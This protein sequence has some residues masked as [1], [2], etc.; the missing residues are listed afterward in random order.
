MQEPAKWKCNIRAAVLAAL[1]LIPFALLAASPAKSPQTRADLDRAISLLRQ[2]AGMF[3]ADAGRRVQLAGLLMRGGYLA[4]ARQELESLLAKQPDHVAGILLLS[5]LFRL[6]FQ[7]EEGRQWMEKARSLAP[8]D[9]SVRLLEADYAKDRHDFAA[10]ADILQRMRR[11]SQVPPEALCALG[12]VHY[13]ENRF[14]QAVEILKECVALDPAN[15]RA[16][17]FLSLIHRVRQENEEWKTKGR[18]SV[19]CDPFDAEALANL[20]NI[21]MRGEKKLK[22]GYREAQQSLRFN[23]YCLTAHIYLG[24]GWTSRHYREDHPPSGAEK[25]RRWRELMQKAEKALTGQDWNEAR[26]AL[27]EAL[28]LHPRSLPA[29]IRRGSVD[30]LQGNCRQALDWFFR[31]LRI[32]PGYGLAHYGI[33]QSLIRIRDRIN[34]RFAGIEHRFA[35]LDAP[36]PDGMRQVFPNY[37]QLDADL[38]KIVR[39]SVQPLR[40]YLP[41]LHR[42]GGTFYL[43]PFHHFLWQT[44]HLEG[45]KGKRTFD[46]RLWDDV[47]GAGGLHAAAGA[48]WERDVKYLRFNVLSHEF[49]HQVHTIL[50]DEMKNEIRRLYNQARQ[51]RRTLDF[52]SDAN[53]FE[54]FAVGVEA[55]VSE[56][57]LADQKITYGH[58]RQELKDKDPD[59]YDFITRLEKEAAVSGK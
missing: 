45:L 50:P 58:T 29:L 10:A 20:S 42:H 36:E 46:L 43:T 12:E 13:W 56:E 23:P 31:A 18:R 26:A 44:P 48:E 59:L 16:W 35:G 30:Y 7:F 6:Q 37:H 14:D 8:G 54:Y 38:Q 47:K 21:L 27:D 39:I 49:A 41:A 52:Y 51:A 24:N 22:E 57:K 4:P 34:I 19:A 15:A 1:L 11:E 5:R 9:I 25:A 32:D 28:K 17:L 2:E 33:S 40:A 3:P 53:E 55:F